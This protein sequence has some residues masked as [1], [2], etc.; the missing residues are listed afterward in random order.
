M[1]KAWCH[2]WV[3]NYLLDS[4]ISDI[5]AQIML[6]SLLGEVLVGLVLVCCCALFSDSSVW[7]MP[8][9]HVRLLAFGQRLH[10]HAFKFVISD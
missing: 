7:A 1:C 6:L 10:L 4:S 8:N 5:T 2:G 3:T 9:W